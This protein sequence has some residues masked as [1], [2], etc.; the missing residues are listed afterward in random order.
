MAIINPTTNL[1]N[2]TFLR[3]TQLC[4]A[5]K[6]V[7]PLDLHM[8]LGNKW[9]INW[10]HKSRLSRLIEHLNLL[11]L[12]SKILDKTKDKPL[13]KTKCYSTIS[14]TIVWVQVNLGLQLVKAK[15]RVLNYPPFSKARINILTINRRCLGK[16]SSTFTKTPKKRN[17]SI[18]KK[19]GKMNSKD[20]METCL[21]LTWG[22]LVLLRI[23]KN[24]SSLLNLINMDIT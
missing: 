12:L 2:K 11:S 17:I 23:I 18:D 19:L 16:T 14:F 22:S 3:A 4:I 8:P 24:S 5:G 10:S 15:N 6:D 9:W 1:L 20:M 13:A 7:R 21:I